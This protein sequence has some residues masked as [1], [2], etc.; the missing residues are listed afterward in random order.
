MVYKTFVQRTVDRGESNRF[1]TV[2]KNGA[3]AFDLFLTVTKQ[4]DRITIGDILFERFADALEILLKKRLRRSVDT[5][6]C[7]CVVRPGMK[8]DMHQRRC[9][10]HEIVGPYKFP[11]HRL[12]IGKPFIVFVDRLFFPKAVDT[13]TTPLHIMRHKRS[14]GRQQLGQ[15]M[16]GRV[17]A[18]YFG[19]NPYLVQLFLRQL[20]LHIER[21]YRIDFV[22]E[23]IDTVRIFVRK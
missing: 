19:N 17:V 7:R 6:D 10:L 18:A 11:T 8:T 23:E 14:A 16:V 20:G 5:Q 9:C 15:L 21:P 22:P 3:D 13:F 4:I 2:F 1:A 12:A